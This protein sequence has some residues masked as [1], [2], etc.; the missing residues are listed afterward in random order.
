[1]K[2]KYVSFFVLLFV[3]TSAFSQKVI[4][5]TVSNLNNYRWQFEAA[6]GESKGITPYKVGYFS[7][8][9]SEKF[10]TIVMNAVDLG[11]TYNFSKLLDFKVNIGFDR[12][13]NKSQKS[14]PFESA[15]F[16]TTFQGVF[17][18]NNLVRFQPDNSRFKLVL[19]GGIS[20]SVL[21]NVAT[22]TN[23]KPVSKDLNGGIVYGISPMFRISKKTHLFLDLSSYTNFRQHR[24]WDGNHAANSENLTGKMINAAIGLNISFGKQVHLESLEDKNKR[25]QDSTFN[26]RVNNLEN[27]LNDTDKDGVAD[28]LDLENNSLA[29]STV[30]S[31]GIMIDKNKN[32]V[33]DV[34][35]KYFE[36]NYGD[37]DSNG[38]LSQTDANKAAKPKKSTDFIKKSIN[39][40][41]I[42]V[43]FD[44][45]KSKPSSLSADN[46]NYILIF[47]NK[48]PFTFLEIIGHGDGL[49]DVKANEKLAYKR[50][51]E[52]KNIL[53]NSGI[54][55]ERI[56]IPSSDEYNTD[57]NLSFTS[58]LV[59][60][61][62]FKVN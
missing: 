60:R 50:A 37:S 11:L 21:Q 16:R 36:E 18:L 55:E 17:N 38:T 33:P 22:S 48:N 23:N 29:G 46:I 8:D 9:E 10:G 12:F 28:Y 62:T 31:R 30:D 49:K 35:E 14:L 24:S 19:H 45:N 61:V 47:L 15:Q 7:S 43:L 39:D 5:S 34:I 56:F 54:K 6:I 3:S 13:S 26:S 57:A 2:T 44:T 42:S 52:V 59:K 41:Y 40:G 27:K 25:L 58:S 53:L 20:L 51:V 1:M 4:D 32:N